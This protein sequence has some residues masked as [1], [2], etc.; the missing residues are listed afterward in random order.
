MAGD[1]ENPDFDTY[2][3]G[4]LSERIM[5]AAAAHGLGSAIGWFRG[6]AAEEA[7]RILQVPAPRLLRTIMSIGYVDA[8]AR[9]QRQ[10]PAQPRKPLEQIVHAEHW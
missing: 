4:R 5:L 2:D 7:K 8:D 10:R 3:E 1:L 6:G 9:R